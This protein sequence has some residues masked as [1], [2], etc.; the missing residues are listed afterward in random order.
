MHLKIIVLEGETTGGSNLL[1]NHAEPF[2]APKEPEE[3]FIFK[4]VKV[5]T[6]FTMIK[7]KPIELRFWML[8]MESKFALLNPEAFKLYIR[9]SYG[10]ILIF[11]ISD[12]TTLRPLVNYI[13]IIKEAAGDIPI[14]LVG[15]KLDLE[16]SCEIS[17]EEGELFVKNYGLT[18]YS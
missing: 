1:E 4:G 10:A 15:N 13:K 3:P 18:A 8:N 2:Y 16:S 6:T 7:K 5:F 17:T 14:M 11:D 9:D 12:Y